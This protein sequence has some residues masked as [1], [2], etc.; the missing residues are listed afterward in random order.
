MQVVSNR[1]LFKARTLKE[2]IKGV[3][4]DKTLKEVQRQSLGDE[5]VPAKETEDSRQRGRR[6]TRRGW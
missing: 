2:I 6:E 1:M 4:E 5:E 3:R